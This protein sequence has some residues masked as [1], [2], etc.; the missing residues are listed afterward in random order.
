MFQQVKAVFH[1]LRQMREYIA[2]V[3]KASVH[4][5]NIT[6]DLDHYLR[7]PKIILNAASTIP[8]L[9][10]FFVSKTLYGSAVL[11]EI[12]VTYVALSMTWIFAL[13]AFSEEIRLGIH[14]S[15]AFAGSMLQT[16]QALAANKSSL[17]TDQSVDL[18]DP[19]SIHRAYGNAYKIAPVVVRVIISGWFEQTAVD[20]CVLTISSLATIILNSWFPI[21]SIDNYSLATLAFAISTTWLLRILF[22]I[23]TILLMRSKVVLMDEFGEIEESLREIHHA[24]M[25]VFSDEVEQGKTRQAENDLSVRTPES[26]VE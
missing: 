20:A 19:V 23:F 6:P 17:D 14:S 25:I 3:K 8:L 24:P 18:S 13:A 7:T 5:K 22:L 12:S 26:T 2:L 15:F 4:F 16:A 10:V 11:S 9:A 1:T 21:L